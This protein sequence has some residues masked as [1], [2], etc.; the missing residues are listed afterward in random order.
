M[1]QK[2]DIRESKDGAYIKVVNIGIGK[3][4][5]FEEVINNFEHTNHP[6][7]S[8]PNEL[9]SALEASLNKNEKNMFQNIILSKE[10]SDKTLKNQILNLFIKECINKSICAFQDKKPENKDGNNLESK[11]LFAYYGPPISIILKL[12]IDSRLIESGF[13]DLNLSLEDFKQINDNTF[14]LESYSEEDNVIYNSIGLSYRFLVS[15]TKEDIFRLNP[16][17][18]DDFDLKKNKGSRKFMELLLMP[19][20]SKRTN[21]YWMCLDH[22]LFY[23][24]Q[25]APFDRI[26]MSENN[27]LSRNN[28]ENKNNVVYIVRNEDGIVKYIGEGKET[29]PSHVNSGISHVYELNKA[30]FEGK[31]LNVEIYN[32]N[33]TKSEALAIERLLLNKYRKCGLWNKKDY[34]K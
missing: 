3:D 27:L 18:R 29:R 17:D 13:Y 8:I 24:V 14:S 5:G 9:K 25:I 4:D 2:K 26:N 1:N 19:H 31:R 22:F 32:Q 28:L 30:H 6:V 23:E 34:V 33:L 20:A 7:V 11:F 21:D 12:I 15:G 10:C 16:F